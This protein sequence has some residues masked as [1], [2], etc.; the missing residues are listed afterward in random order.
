MGKVSTHVLID[1]EMRNLAKS[2]NISLSRTLNEALALKLSIPNTR[3]EIITKK[4]K[5][6]QELTTL[7]KKELE[8]TALDKIRKK[9]TVINELK[10][11]VDELRESWRAFIT[12]P[13]SKLGKLNV[14]RIDSV[15]K[16]WDAT[17]ASFCKKWGVEKVVALMYADGTKQAED[18]I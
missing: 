17:V 12:R 2:R 7:E 11:D 13:T 10:K 8:L 18:G 1:E 4:N 14:G 3:E 16:K 5:L 9:K 15:S 6:K